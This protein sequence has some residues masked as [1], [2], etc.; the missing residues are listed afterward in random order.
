MSETLEEIMSKDN[1]NKKGQCPLCSHEPEL[2]ENVLEEMY[3]LFGI[4]ICEGCYHELINHMG[5]RNL[6]DLT[7]Y[8]KKQLTR[9]LNMLSAIKRG[10][11]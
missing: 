11:K 6:D 3:D 10:E 4:E 5:Y 9:F 1:L 7:N 8:D 2:G